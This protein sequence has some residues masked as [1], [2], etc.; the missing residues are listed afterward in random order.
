MITSG[1]HCLSV[2]NEGM[3]QTDLRAL[4]AKRLHPAAAHQT[5]D[6]LKAIHFKSFYMFL[7]DLLTPL[8]LNK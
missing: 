4:F 1:R 7:H 6:Q 5:N 2:T 8:L 3:E